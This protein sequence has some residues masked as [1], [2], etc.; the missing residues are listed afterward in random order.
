[1]KILFHILLVFTFFSAS[2]AQTTSK[3]YVCRKETKELWRELAD[4]GRYH[5]AIN[6]LMDSIQTSKQK[7]KKSA[8]WHVGQLYACNNEY[9]VAIEYLKKSKSRPTSLNP[10]T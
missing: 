5:E 2:M 8:Y 4:S 3:D 1:M 10:K 6:I 9:E 7:N